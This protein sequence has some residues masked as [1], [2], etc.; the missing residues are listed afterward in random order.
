[1]IKKISKMNDFLKTIYQ[2]NYG[3]SD[4]FHFLKSAIN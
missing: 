2:E 1:M 4:A 3:L